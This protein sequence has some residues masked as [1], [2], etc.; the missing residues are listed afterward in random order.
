MPNEEQKITYFEP[1]EFEVFKF[2]CGF[3]AK[4]NT[5]QRASIVN[6]ILMFNPILAFNRETKGLD[7]VCTVSV[8]GDAIQLNLG[9]CPHA[10]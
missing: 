9:E 4:C 6:E 5:D 1:E 7:S 3:I 2:F 10:H 8:N